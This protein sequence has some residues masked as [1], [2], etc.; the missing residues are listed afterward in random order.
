MSTE[1]PLNGPTKW[2]LASNNSGKLAEIQQILA[3]LDIQLIPQ[4]Q[5]GFEEVEETGLSFIENSILKA[6]H[7]SLQTGLPALADDSGIEVFA[8]NGEPGIYS[9]RYAADDDY[10]GELDTANVNKLLANMEGKTNRNARFVC[11]ITLI[12]HGNDPTPAIFEGFWNGEINHQ[13]AGG[14]GFGYDPIFYLK[15]LDCTSAEISANEK[16]KLSHRGK[17]LEKLKQFLEDPD[18]ASKYKT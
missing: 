5:F 2:V 8:L 6:R 13:P 10:D 3:D 1:R 11:A 12:Q 4:K 17:A 7:A 9:A 14:G 18:K 16:A 15:A